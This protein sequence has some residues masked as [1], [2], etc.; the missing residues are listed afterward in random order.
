MMLSGDQSSR[1]EGKGCM[2]VNGF[3]RSFCFILSQRD[4]CKV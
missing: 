4:F 2:G 1:L 3:V